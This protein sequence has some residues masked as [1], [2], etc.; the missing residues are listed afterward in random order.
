MLWLCSSPLFA[1]MMLWEH[2]TVN[3]GNVGLSLCSEQVI[4]YLIQLMFFYSL[5]F[6]YDSLITK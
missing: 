3:Q 5:C 1:H 2:R 4:C 6:Y